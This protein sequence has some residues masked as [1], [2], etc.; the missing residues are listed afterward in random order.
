MAAP[1]ADLIAADGIFVSLGGLP[2]L[3]D[4]SLHVAP[5][6]AVAVLGGNGS[7]KSTL[8]R[9]VVGLNPIQE[10]SVRL[11]GEPLEAFRDWA[12]IG[13]VPQHSTLNVNNATVTEI[14]SSG[15]LSHHKPFRWFRKADRVAVEHALELV[16]LADRAKWPFRTLSGGQKQ[17]TLIARALSTEP[18]LLVMDEPFAGVDLHSQAGLANLLAGLRADGMG[19]AVVLHEL[20]P[21]AP[22][23]DRSITLCDGRVVEHERAGSAANCEPSSFEDSAVG[24]LDPVPRGQ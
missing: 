19:M 12:R 1:D 18:E 7:G 16:G 4:V 20:G 9:A 24:L 10:G 5:R 15:R 17:R 13:Y 22:V 3:R 11:F 8:I 21:M 2:I 6:E 23:L 14:A